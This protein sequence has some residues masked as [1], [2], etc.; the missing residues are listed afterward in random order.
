M[1]AP[2][3]PV[4]VSLGDRGPL[5]RREAGVNTPRSSTNGA[6]APLQARF[7]GPSRHAGS[8]GG[9]TCQFRERSGLEKR[10]FVS[11]MASWIRPLEATML[12]VRELK[13]PPARR[14]VPARFTTI[15]AP[16]ASH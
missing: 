2:V 4:D 13:T 15:S 6:S 8:Y 16:A 11:T 5:R 14:D 7:R 10:A 1:T 9:V 3:A 12:P